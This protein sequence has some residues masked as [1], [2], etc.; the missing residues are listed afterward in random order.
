[1]EG[2]TRTII[3]RQHP[4]WAIMLRFPAIDIGVRGT[5]GTEGSATWALLMHHDG[6]AT[7]T[8]GCTIHSFLEM[9]L[10]LV[11]C[12]VQFGHGHYIFARIWPQYCIAMKIAFHNYIITTFLTRV[13]QRPVIQRNCIIYFRVF[14]AHTYLY[15]H[16]IHFTSLTRRMI[17]YIFPPWQ[18]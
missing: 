18:Q 1:M 3:Y 9:E 10:F 16:K 5:L 4:Q 17:G 12:Y 2:K 6:L 8:T 15:T 14:I 7:R 11:Q 13:C